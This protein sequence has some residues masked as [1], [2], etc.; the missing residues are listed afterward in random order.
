MASAQSILL[1]GVTGSLGA[2]ILE[3]LLNNGNPVTAVLRS[4]QNSK[5]PLEKKYENEV[6]VGKLRFLE[7]PDMTVPD[8]FYAAAKGPGAIIHVAT[9]IGK[10][11]MLED[12]IKPTDQI[13]VNVLKA[14]TASS[15]VQRVIVTGSIVSVFSFLHYME[16]PKICT[17]A[18]FNDITLD[19]ALT[20]FRLAYTYSKTS[21]EQ[22]AW[23]Y[24]H[25]TPQRFDLIFLLAPS[26]YG[27]SI[28]SGFRAAKGNAGGI[29]AI[30]TQL[31]DRDSL[32]F[33]FPYVM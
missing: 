28:Q 27:K 12:M 1:T 7:I 11:N 6:A 5:F 19:E 25:K 9:P 23:E 2:V 32:G 31:F 24:M 4:F 10:E 14:A 29:P 21:S 17:E 18:D 15:T 30:Y 26:I 20:Q 33:L 8:A 22:K 13:I 16:G 3:Q